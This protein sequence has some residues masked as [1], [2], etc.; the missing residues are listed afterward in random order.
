MRWSRKIAT[1]KAAEQSDALRRVFQAR[2][3]ANYTAAQVVALDESACNERTG[4][5]KYG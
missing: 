3:Q 4:N 1:K 5:R 2:I